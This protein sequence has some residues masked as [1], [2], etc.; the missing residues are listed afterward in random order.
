MKDQ[1]HKKIIFFSYHLPTN[2]QPGAFR[3]WMEAILLRDAGAE[4]TV[5]T[6]AIHYMTGE[7]IRQSTGWCVETR[8]EKVRILHVWAPGNHRRSLWH[9]I[10]NYVCFTMTSFF[11]AVFRSGPADVVFAGTDPITMMPAVYLTAVLKRAQLVLDERDLYPETAIA[12][13]AVRDGGLTR[14]LFY[15]QQFFRRRSAAILA[16]TPGIRRKLIEYGHPIQKI[17]LLYN[18]DVLDEPDPVASML[19]DD[20]RANTG[21]QF[22]I[23]Y[24]GGLGKVNDV[25]TLLRAV[26]HLRDI[27]G[28]G[29]V[30]VGAGERKTEYMDFADSHKLDNVF[31]F[32]AVPRR[33]ARQLICQLDIGL[34]ALPSDPHFEA[35][36]TSKTFD[37]HAA[38]V[39]M[40]CCASG[41]TVDL[42]AES[43]GGFGVPPEAAGELANKIRELWQSPEEMSRLSN[44]AR[45]WY[46]QNIS[47]TNATRIVTHLLATATAAETPM[48]SEECVDSNLCCVP[49][50]EAAIRD[51]YARRD[52]EGKANLYR[53]CLPSV[54]Y[55]AYRKQVAW[56]KAIHDAEEVDL[57]KLRILDVGCGA[58]TW[59]R[60]LVEWGASPFRLHGIDLL[61]DRI[62]TAQM[63]SH[64]DIDFKCGSA[65]PLPY[66]RASF[67]LVAASTVMSSILTPHARRK[68]ASELE[69][70]VQPNG[71]IMI[72]DFV[73]SK[74]RNP[75][76]VGITTAEIKRLFSHCRYERRIHVTL[77]PPLTR[78]LT[79]W[80]PWIAHAIECVCPFLCTHRLHILRRDPRIATAPKGDAR[81]PHAA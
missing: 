31:F 77:L 51:R 29:L 58:G 7:D 38:G 9:R 72:Y 15:L 45:Q 11:A 59:L 4:V 76:T 68:L 1:A 41:D 48:T 55:D 28:L 17:Q 27:Q 65:W 40:L 22:L 79:K 70:V 20:L 61:A 47:P 30:I 36:L 37:Y 33:I 64:A 12:I 5:I 34:Q 78:L 60:M 26:A 56:A 69:R 19:T 80:C 71:Q 62:S 49:A 14:A 6:S 25:M 21:K 18:A 63:R 3:P 32:D 39:P 74:P 10:M 24:V 73:V 54:S 23:G 13:G 52:A 75:H 53:P 44:S 67:D 2:D 35:T 8:V 46:R 66:E 43:G 57:S 42:L 16:A 81:L 50:E